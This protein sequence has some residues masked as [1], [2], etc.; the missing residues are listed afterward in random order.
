MFFFGVHSGGDKPPDVK[1]DFYEIRICGEGISDTGGPIDAEFH[2]VS[3]PSHHQGEFHQK[4]P[5]LETL[6]LEDL[7]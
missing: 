2:G 4:N 5:V 1:P 7:L 3:L 6:D